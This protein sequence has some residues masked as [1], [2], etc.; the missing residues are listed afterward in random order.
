[1][2]LTKPKQLLLLADTKDLFILRFGRPVVPIFTPDD[3][4]FEIGK[5]V[6]MTE[7]KDVTIVAT[8]HLVW[9]ALQ[10]SEILFEQGIEAEIINTHTIKPLDEEAIL[11]SVEKTG[12]IVTAEE[13]NY[14]WRFGRKSVLVY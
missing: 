11:K 3:Q 12:C 9:E 8:G 1:M 4:K 6:Q 10:A 7:G 14:G 2:I 5:A 13:H